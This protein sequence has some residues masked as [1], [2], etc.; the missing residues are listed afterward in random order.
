MIQW[1][2]V[3]VS[4]FVSIFNCTSVSDKKV[5][6]AC[7]VSTFLAFAICPIPFDNC[8]TTLFFQSLT[9]SISIFGLE[10]VT[11][12]FFKDSASSRTFA[13]CK[14]VF[15]GIQPLLRQ[16]PPSVGSLSTNITFRPRSAALKA[17]A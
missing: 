8:E 14:S 13:M 2:N 1:S 3:I 6:S 10:K 7:T 5:A 4:F 12:I 16:T 15:E 17:A 11:P 9:E